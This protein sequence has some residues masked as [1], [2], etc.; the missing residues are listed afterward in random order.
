[1]RSGLAAHGQGAPG[2]GLRRTVTGS[3]IHIRIGDRDESGRTPHIEAAI[4]SGWCWPKAAWDSGKMVFRRQGRIS[5]H[6]LMCECDKSSR[7]NGFVTAIVVMKETSMGGSDSRTP[8]Q[9][10]EQEV[11]DGLL[12]GPSSAYRALLGVGTLASA[13]DPSCWWSGMSTRRSECD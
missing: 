2:G 1:A 11:G 8:V 13:E 4:D 3:D 5:K 9:E 7:V 6:L 12:E 10:Q